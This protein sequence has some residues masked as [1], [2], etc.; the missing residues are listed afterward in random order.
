M[1]TSHTAIPRKRKA[2]PLYDGSSGVSYG[3]QPGLSAVR[4]ARPFI[5]PL[6]MSAGLEEATPGHRMKRSHYS[7]IKRTQFP[8]FEEQSM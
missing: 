7:K 8:A 4:I 6:D 5:H 1:S 2:R 3:H